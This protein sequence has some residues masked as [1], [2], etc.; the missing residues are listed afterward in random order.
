MYQTTGPLSVGSWWCCKIT[1]MLGAAIR[2]TFALWKLWRRLW[3]DAWLKQET[4][5]SYP[6]LTYQPWRFSLL[7]CWNVLVRLLVY[8][9][10]IFPLFCLCNYGLY[11]LVFLQQTSK[12]CHTN[13]SIQGCHK[14]CFYRV[15]TRLHVQL[16]FFDETRLTTWIG[17]WVWLGLN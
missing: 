3:N 5:F 6:I 14:A 1:V 13:R 15:N 17:K 8:H 4:E 12:R 9:L 11:D 7:F 2:A 16:L 10:A